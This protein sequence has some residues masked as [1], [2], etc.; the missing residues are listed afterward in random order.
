[1]GAGP[2]PVRR[3]LRGRAGK[4]PVR[5]LLH[6][7]SIPDAR[8]ADSARNRADCAVRA[9]F[10]LMGDFRMNRSNLMNHLARFRPAAALIALALALQS[11][12]AFAR[13]SPAPAQKPSG[14]KA[15]SDRKSTR[16]NSSHLG[17]SY[18]VFC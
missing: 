3:F 9:L 4:T 7:E 13:W 6:Q 5:S 16:L 12:Q 11:Q 1:M 14:A 18:A 15:G 17:I 2:L 8:R 10:T